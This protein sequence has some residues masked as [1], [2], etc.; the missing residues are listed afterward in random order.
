MI[1]STAEAVAKLRA[2]NLVAIPTETVYGLAARIDD[3]SALKQIF[4]VKK[5]PFFD[6]LIVHVTDL[7]QA[8]RLVIDWPP[9][10]D[11]LAEAF[12]PGP[13]TLVAKKAESVS[14]LITSGLDTVA[15]R[16]PNHPVAQEILRALSIPLAA[17]SANLF[18]RTSPTKAAHVEKEFAEKVSVVDGGASEIGVE[19]TVVG[20]DPAT[21]DK[22]HVLRPGGVSRHEIRQLLES[23]GLKFEVVRTQS[24]ASPGHLESHYQPN[25]PVI[26]LES[27]EWHDGLKNSI[28]QRLDRPI[29]HVHFMP[30]K[31]SAQLAARKLYENFREF[32]DMPGA[33][34]VIPRLPENSTPEWEAVW[35]RIERAAILRI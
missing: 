17:P 8:K 22:L 27:G 16:C 9:V 4:E 23:K 26:I 10:F 11:V 29:T 20:Y 25:C 21:P 6:P 28:A 14:A 30:M 15:I 19:S 7:N 12:W 18:G 1:V 3:D 33:A 13:L 31:T 2:G 35:D 24:H 5:R 34:I 32:S